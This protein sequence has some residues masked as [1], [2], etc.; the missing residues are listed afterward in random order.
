MMSLRRIGSK[1]VNVRRSS[2]VRYGI[3][4]LFPRAVATG[5]ILVITPLGIAALGGEAFGLWL[6]ATYITAIVV[7]P[8]LGLGN[9]VVNDFASIRAAG[10]SLSTQARRIRGLTRMLFVVAGLW[11]IVGTAGISLYVL[12]LAG[13]ENRDALFWSLVLGLICFLLAVPTAIL[14]RI[15]LA[16]ER[17]ARAV[18]WEGVGKVVAVGA[19]ITVLLIAPNV[20]LLV[21]AY[22]LPVSVCA[23][24]NALNFCRESGIRVWRGGPSISRAFRE[25]RAFLG[26]GRWFLLIQV[27]YLM[28]SSADPYILNAFYGE[29][30]VVYVNVLRRPYEVLTLLVSMYAIALW[31]VFRRFV[32]AGEVVKLKRLFVWALCAS[33]ALV[34]VGGAAIMVAASSV[35]GYLG[36]GTVEAKTRDLW[37]LLLLMAATAAVMIVSNFLNALSRVRGQALFFVCGSVGVLSMKFVAAINS[38]VHGFVAAGAISYFILLGVP[39]LLYAWVSLRRSSAGSASHPMRGQDE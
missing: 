2:V 12:S 7:S 33:I 5:G 22:M 4:S 15:Q 21:V 37:S 39:L 6:L 17:A 16:Y 8:D 11:L 32:L 28:L 13:Q 29:H 35:Y 38:D 27:S 10:E 9:S 14:Q 18:L 30:G 25:N 31:P 34:F 36:A 19:S 24:I 20:H 1:I 23:W 3:A 26:V